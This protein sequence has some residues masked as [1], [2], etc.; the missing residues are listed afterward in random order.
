M[1][2]PHPKEILREMRER[3]EQRLEAIKV[4]E[5]RLDYALTKRNFKERE[6]I[7]RALQTKGITAKKLQAL[8]E[9]IATDVRFFLITERNWANRQKETTFADVRNRSPFTIVT[10]VIRDLY[11]DDIADILTHGDA[12]TVI[13]EKFLFHP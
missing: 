6:Q 12:F 13:V 11:A 7:T 5:G 2:I 3:K 1:N 4:L 8:T 10:T 9:I